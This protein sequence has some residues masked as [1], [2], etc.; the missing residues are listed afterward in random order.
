[1]GAIL[2]RGG[3]GV[4]LHC[5][6]DALGSV[7]IKC[8]PLHGS[9]REIQEAGP[10]ALKEVK[11][12]SQLQH[13]NL[14]R[15]LGT[16]R[17]PLWLGLIMEIMHGGTLHDLLKDRRVDLPYPLRTCFS[18]DIVEGLS[19]LHKCDSKSEKRITHG[20]MKAH[21]IILS[22]NLICKICDLGTAK[23]ANVTGHTTALTDGRVP[24]TR[25]YAAPERLQ[26]PDSRPTRSMDIY[27]IGV[28]FQ[29]IITREV[30]TTPFQLLDKNAHKPEGEDEA[31]LYKLISRLHKV[32]C[33]KRP[34]ERPDVTHFQAEL[35]KCIARKQCQ[36]QRPS[37]TAKVLES[38]RIVGFKSTEEFIIPFGRAVKDYLN[39]PSTFS[40]RNLDQD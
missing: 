32:A 37:L 31:F 6:L 39:N 23:L 12:L 5:H 27:S 4:V 1:M 10:N 9:G 33:S 17:G 19:Y 30:P 18:L 35:S 22:Q 11:T 38:Y 13:P 3:H 8:V 7:A 26:C 14:V 20:D 16:T 25:A 36:Q 24:F 2:G 21:N 28:I 29:F 34:S 40:S 15:L